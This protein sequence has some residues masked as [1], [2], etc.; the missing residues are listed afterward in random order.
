M[1]M[2]DQAQGDLEQTVLTNLINRTRGSCFDSIGGLVDLGVEVF[3]WVV[4][5]SY[6]S[7]DLEAAE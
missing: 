1:V 6:N 7:F 4:C 3:S 2:G 5:N